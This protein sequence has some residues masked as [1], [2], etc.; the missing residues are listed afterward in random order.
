MIWH[1]TYYNECWL[2]AKCSNTVYLRLWFCSQIFNH[3]FT[4]DIY[5]SAKVSKPGCLWWL[6][7]FLVTPLSFLAMP[8]CCGLFLDVCLDSPH[9]TIDYD[10]AVVVSGCTRKTW[11][12][13]MYAVAVAQSSYCDIV[14]R[15]ETAQ[16][17]SHW[18]WL[19]QLS[20][21]QLQSLEEA[22]LARDLYQKEGGTLCS[23]WR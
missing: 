13:I 10:F 23:V 16:V 11:P 19:V 21:A 12:K 22:R 8:N 14:C 15:L 17:W 5:C 7:I 1:E 4:N 6:H 9:H 3:W 20:Q 18:M 2:N